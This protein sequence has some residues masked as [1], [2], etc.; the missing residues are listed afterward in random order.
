MKIF[1]IIL[2][3]PV[4]VF[5]NNDYYE[6]SDKNKDIKRSIYESCEDLSEYE[7]MDMNENRA[8]ECDIYILH[9]DNNREYMKGQLDKRKKRQVKL[10]KKV[11]IEKA[12][13]KIPNRDKLNVGFSLNSYENEY[14]INTFYYEHFLNDYFYIGGR[15]GSV[16]YLKLDEDMKGTKN[17]DDEVFFAFNPYIGLDLLNST[18]Y[19]N[20]GAKLGFLFF[21]GDDN[22]ILPILNF[23][24]G[25]KISGVFRINTEFGYNYGGVIIGMLI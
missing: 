25:F 3:F 5:S 8:S 19:F 9:P 17:R 6:D 2:I 13:A 7:K 11:K 20:L 21:N 14:Q 16:S 12:E 23:T 22:N 18:K 24:L 1:I 15:I 10:K 4:L